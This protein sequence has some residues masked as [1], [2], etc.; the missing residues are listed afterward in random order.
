MSAKADNFLL[1]KGSHL[2]LAEARLKYAGQLKDRF[3]RGPARFLLQ[4]QEAAG[5]EKLERRLVQEVDAALRFSCQ[6]WCR[7]ETPLVRGLRD[8]TDETFKFNS[9]DMQLYQKRAPLL[10]KPIVGAVLEQGPPACDGGPPVVMVL[11]PSISVSTATNTEG[12][13]KGRKANTRIWTKASVLVA[14]PK[15][16]TE[17]ALLTQQP[18]SLDA[19]S[20]K[21]M[22]RPLIS[23]E[24]S[25]ASPMIA[26]ESVL[27]LPSKA[28]KNVPHSLKQSP[29]L[30]LPLAT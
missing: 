6:L 9:N 8:L 2:P 16:P 1:T 11:Q 22:V 4:S 28:F 18:T 10:A 19:A 21:A 15:I 29:S 27:I 25:S 12:T 5:I 14:T 3:L 7:K 24:D 20:V 26:E 13:A 23:P 17:E 30:P